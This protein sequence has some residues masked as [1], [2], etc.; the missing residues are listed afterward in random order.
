MPRITHHDMAH[1]H[2]SLPRFPRQPLHSMYSLSALAYGLAILTRAHLIERTRH[3]PYESQQVEGVILGRDPARRTL[4]F[5]NY[6]AIENIILVA[7]R[8]DDAL[9]QAHNIRTYSYK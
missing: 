6:R 7:S 5:K 3:T 8:G 1:E 4:Y 2:M 9:D